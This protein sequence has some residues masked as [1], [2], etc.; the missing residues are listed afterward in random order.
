MFNKL[1]GL[2]SKDQLELRKSMTYFAAELLRS[3][4]LMS[5]NSKKMLETFPKKLNFLLKLFKEI[6]AQLLST[7]SNSLE[8]KFKRI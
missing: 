3:V 7:S 1:D 5:M 8:T 6:D 4:L 2:V